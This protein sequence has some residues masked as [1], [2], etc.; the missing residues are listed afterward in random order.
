M[1]A[2]VKTLPHN[3]FAVIRVIS[4]IGVGEIYYQIE[5]RSKWWPFWRRASTRYTTPADA[6]SV[7]EAHLLVMDYLQR[8][9]HEPNVI[10]KG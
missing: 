8:T 7:A 9:V 10:W 4:V 3:H 1:S 6:I 5:R 2:P